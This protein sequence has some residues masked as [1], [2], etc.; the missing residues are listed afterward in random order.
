MTH[1][2]SSLFHW[3]SDDTKVTAH[4]A[5]S[6]HGK[7]IHILGIY[8]LIRP[9][10][11][12]ISRFAQGFR[13]HWARLHPPPPVLAD[14]TWIDNMLSLLPSKLPLTHMMPVDLDW[15]G[16]T[17][18][19]FGI[20]VTVGHHW[21]IWQ[22]NP[23]VIVGPGH[24]FDIGWAEAVAIEMGLRMVLDEQLLSPNLYLVR[25]D[26]SG[27]VTA[28]NKGQSRSRETNKVLI[29]IFT[30]LACH[31]AHLSTIYVPSHSNVTDALS[32]GDIPSFLK[33]FPQARNRSY[34]PIPHHL[35]HLMCHFK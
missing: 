27:V 9:F 23:G 18:T 22:W 31:G 1:I 2:C 3:L 32:R 21:A 7:L 34:P 28:L 30:I 17:S 26:N 33:G 5:A 10:L 14:I 4:E 12:S 8:P 20:G 25:S 29:N 24:Q 13:S 15:W 11:Q 35:S 19:S 6:L 16:D